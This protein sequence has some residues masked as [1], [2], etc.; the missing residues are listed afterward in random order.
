MQ[1]FEKFDFADLDELRK[2]GP[3]LPKAEKFPLGV[4]LQFKN[5]RDFAI[6]G[7]ADR[8]WQVASAGYSLVQ[9]ETVIN[10]VVS[11]MA[12]L[13]LEG[14]KG[15]V[16]TWNHGGRMWIKFVTPKTFE[17][18]AGDKFNHGVWFANSYDGSAAVQ[19]GYYAYRQ[20]CSNGMM[21]W[22]REIA[23]RQIHLGIKG[24]TEWLREAI[25]K[26]RA[27]EEIFEKMIQESAQVRL[28]EDLETVLKRLSVGPKVIEKIGKRLEVDQGVTA[29]N[30]ANAI[31]EYA[32]HE[33]KE[34]PVAAQ[35]YNRLA[36][37]ILLKPEILCV[38]PA[39]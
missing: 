39:K 9:H 10:S 5:A 21:G 2:I 31:A 28:T 34:R 19:G 18:F 35:D 8:I 4:E 23:A 26:I 3:E 30:V 36:E 17:P 32:T 12:T 11:E 38:V 6:V 7:C 15:H 29:Y 24:I 25:G 14:L 37:R 22:A 13:G 33:L 1:R 20:V 27:K 16:D